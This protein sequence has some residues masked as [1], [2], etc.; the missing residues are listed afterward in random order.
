MGHGTTMPFVHLLF[1]V[2]KS[3]QFSVGVVVA[4]VVVVVFFLRFQ[5]R[6]SMLLFAIQKLRL[7]SLG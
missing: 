6:C 4:V 7:H 3:K 1:A 5:R 2:H